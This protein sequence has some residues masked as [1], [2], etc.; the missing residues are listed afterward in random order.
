[1]PEL[2][3]PCLGLLPLGK[4]DTRV[5]FNAYCNYYDGDEAACNNAVTTLK[6]DPSMFNLC[7]FDSAG[8]KCKQSGAEISHCSPPPTRPSDSWH[9]SLGEAIETVAADMLPPSSCAAAASC[10][11]SV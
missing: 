2:S 4:V 5:Q 10:M 6:N 3:D 11:E 7:A 9:D 8:D 1:M